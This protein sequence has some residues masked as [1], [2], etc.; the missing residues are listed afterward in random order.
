MQKRLKQ[1]VISIEPKDLRKARST[2]KELTFPRIIA[3]CVTQFGINR[4]CRRNSRNLY[5]RLS[6]KKLK[7]G[8]VVLEKRQKVSKN[9]QNFDFSEGHN[10]L[11]QKIGRYP[12]NKGASHIPFF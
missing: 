2:N 6:K 4:L 11:C 3:F 12:V 9:G 1:P 7:F 10:F 8:R 5:V